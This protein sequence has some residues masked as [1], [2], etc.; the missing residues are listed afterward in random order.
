MSSKRSFVIA[1]CTQ[2]SNTCDQHQLYNVPFS[3]YAYTQDLPPASSSHPN[4]CH[5]SITQSS[6]PSSNGEPPLPQAPPQTIRIPGYPQ[7][8]PRLVLQSQ[9]QRPRMPAIPSRCRLP[10]GTWVGLVRRMFELALRSR[11]LL[12]RALCRLSVLGG[13]G[14]GRDRL[15][16]DFVS[17][18]SGLLSVIKGV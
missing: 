16:G 12:L 17:M 2:I 5:P 8:H 10:R 3:I 14:L 13:R 7:H 6:H 11:W 15:E 18:G 9:Q 1:Q 4:P